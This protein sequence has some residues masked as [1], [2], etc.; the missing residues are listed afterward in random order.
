VADIIALPLYEP[1]VAGMP[2][3]MVLLMFMGMGIVLAA[4]AIWTEIY[5][6][7]K[8]VWGFRKS[9]KNNIPLSIVT[10]I[11]HKIW[12]EPTEYIAGL[13]KSLGLPLMWILTTTTAAGQMGKVNI[14][15]VSDDWN[16]VHDEDIDY[17][18]V[19]AVNEWNKEHPAPTDQEKEN[20]FIYDW[21]SFEKHLMNGDLDEKFPDGI[22]LP[23]FRVVNTHEI[24]RYL[25]QWKASH[26]AGYINQE[27]AKRETKDK[28]EGKK[29]LMFSIG[30]GVTVI[31]LCAIGY[32]IITTAKC[33]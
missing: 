31:A 19:Y 5:V 10:G 25:P 27:V 32:M 13:F 29:L 7:M 11:N 21:E 16:I 23:P 20:E 1:I 30:A 6:P 2:F 4:I 22:K 14:T 28:D 24:R 8:P 12:F 26:F 33:H 3:Y 17:A 15:K 18:I 9:S